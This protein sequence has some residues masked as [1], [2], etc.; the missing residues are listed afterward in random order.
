[1]RVKETRNQ[2]SLGVIRRTGDVDRQ[3]LTRGLSHGQ[4]RAGP[5]GF[6]LPQLQ[7]E[8]TASVIVSGLLRDKEDMPCACLV[9]HTSAQLSVSP[10]L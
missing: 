8:R 7:A 10:C 6:Q 9:G 5:A 1:M 3:A 2:R 4:A